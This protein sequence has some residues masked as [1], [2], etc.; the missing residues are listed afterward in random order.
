MS[1]SKLITIFE[2]SDEYTA[3]VIDGATGTERRFR[4]VTRAVK[5]E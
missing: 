5:P 1:E 3:D 4:I 2:P